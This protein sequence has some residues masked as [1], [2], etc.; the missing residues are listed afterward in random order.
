VDCLCYDAI[1]AASR[2][3]LNCGV[4]KGVE[5]CGSNYDSNFSSIC[6]SFEVKFVD[7]GCVVSGNFVT[8][9]GPNDVEEFSLNFIK[10][11]KL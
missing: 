6:D 7:E 11:L 1:C 9:C 10:L 3:L 5:C 2:V 4:M 8:A